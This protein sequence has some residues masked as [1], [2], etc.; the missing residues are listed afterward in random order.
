ML[1][2]LLHKMDITLAA[3][4]ETPLLSP[5]ALAVCKPAP[6]LR[7]QREKAPVLVEHTT[8]KWVERRKLEVTSKYLAQC[9]ARCKQWMPTINITVLMVVIIQW[10]VGLLGGLVRHSNMAPGLLGRCIGGAP[11]LQ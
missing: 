2:G 1:S 10:L 5:R 4:C 6:P 7:P 9:L 11:G 8:F 3:S